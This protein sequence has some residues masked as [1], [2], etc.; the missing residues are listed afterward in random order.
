MTRT[1]TM[2]LFL[3]EKQNLLMQRPKRREDTP[4]ERHEDGSVTLTLNATGLSRFFGTRTHRL[5]AVSG[6]VW[7]LADGTRRV[8]EIGKA[9]F[10]E[11]GERVEP[12]QDHVASVI[13]RLH[14]LRTLDF[15]D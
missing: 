1:R 11:F 10:V 8:H 15:L 9:L 12:A 5:D 2:P 4:W 7:E 6:R 3:N 14:K 13:M